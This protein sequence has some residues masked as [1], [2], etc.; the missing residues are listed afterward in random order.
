MEFSGKTAIITGAASGM[1]LLSA[2][3]LAEQGANVVLTDVNAEAVSAAAAGICENGGKAIGVQVD[4]RNYE[5]IQQAVSAGM[6]KFRRI[7]ILINSAGGSAARVFGVYKAFHELDVEIIEWGLDVNLKGALLFSRAVIGQMMKQKSGV[8]INLGSITGLTG[9][10][11]VEYAAAKSGMIGLTKGLAVL[12]SDY[13][14]RSCC[15]TPGPV[16][17]RPGMANMKTLLGRAAEPW[18]VVDLILYLCS[19]KAA[20]ITGSNHVIDGGRTCLAA[21]L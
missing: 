7:D 20:F 18:E 10:G 13:G 9:G 15:V 4:V 5:Q 2:Q 8:I 11:D 6:E 14:V 17:T 19:D 16:L 12:G 1:G 21:K 3:K